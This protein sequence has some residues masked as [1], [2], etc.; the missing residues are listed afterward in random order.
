MGGE[1]DEVASRPSLPKHGNGPRYCP[2]IE[3]KVHRYP[4]R[5]SHSVIIEPEGYD[6]DIVY[7]NGL[8]TSLPEDVQVKLIHTIEGLE[9]AKLLQPGYAVEYD[10]VNPRDLTPWLESKLLP[11]LFLAGQVNGTTGYEEAACQGVV[12]GVNAARV[13]VTRDVS[14]AL[15]IDR[16]QG[17]TGVLVDDLSRL[18]TL[19]PYRMLSSR[20]EYRISLR[21]DNAD[22]RLT[23]LGM[24]IGCVGS[25]R[26]QA[27]LD[28]E[29]LIARGM[30]ALAALQGN[31]REWAD[32]G[33]AGVTKRCN[34]LDLISNPIFGVTL[35]DLLVRVPSLHPAVDQSV[36]QD[37]S[38]DMRYRMFVDRQAKEISRMRETKHSKIPEE[39]DFRSIKGLSNLD[40]DQLVAHRPRTIE[41]AERIGVTASGLL[42]LVGH[43]RRLQCQ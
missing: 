12:A 14:K 13:G 20:A 26:G 28:K 36:V 40:F 41:H 15:V 43:I 30:D 2:S 35:D 16:G 3:A 1:S 34:G 24:T 23:P 11:G 25:H 8:N 6:T 17:L 22:R 42:L 29:K 39:L 10:F 9:N 19:E 31:S 33:I 27:L 5:T 38:T 7:P 4:Q 21:A 18:G 37:I 32:R